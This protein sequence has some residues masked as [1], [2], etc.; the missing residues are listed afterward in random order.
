[1]REAALEGGPGGVPM[2]EGVGGVGGR[3][4]RPPHCHVPPPS[5]WAPCGFAGRPS[6]GGAAG[7]CD[8]GGNLGG[9]AAAW[10]IVSVV[11]EA[12]R[13]WEDVGKTFSHRRR[14]TK[15]FLLN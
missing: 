2:L 7:I 4:T 8:G 5:P 3:G 14:C 15:G 1:M 6:D 13:R 10:A 11:G 9:G 12:L